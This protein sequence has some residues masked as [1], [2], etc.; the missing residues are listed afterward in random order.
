MRNTAGI[1][2]VGNRDGVVK[3]VIRGEDIPGG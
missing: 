1:N 2:R 3:L